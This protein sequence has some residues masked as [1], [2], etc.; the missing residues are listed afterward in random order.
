M[1]VSHKVL[2][3][4]MEGTLPSNQGNRLGKRKTWDPENRVFLTK[5][6]GSLGGRR[7]DTTGVKHTISNRIVHVAIGETSTR[8]KFQIPQGA[9]R[10]T[11]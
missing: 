4:K 3:R 2:R 1:S 7:L 5:E 11:E 9:L 10:F 6:E 8:R